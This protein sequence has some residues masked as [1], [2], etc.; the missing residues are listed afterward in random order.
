MIFLLSLLWE[1]SLSRKINLKLEGSQ[2]NYSKKRGKGEVTLKYLNRLNSI[3]GINWQ[4]SFFLVSGK[5]FE[6]LS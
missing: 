5:V 1:A 6:I 2:E 3:F 4:K